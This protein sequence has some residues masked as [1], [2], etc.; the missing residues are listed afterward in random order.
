MKAKI[1][2]LRAKNNKLTTLE[3]QKQGETEAA[4]AL[5]DCV[6][7]IEG[8]I[9]K[10]LKISMPRFANVS[11]AYFS[12]LPCVITTLANLFSSS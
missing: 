7:Y 1:G 10:R 11:G 4:R 5:D 12:P 2:R 6:K 8:S 9:M 3:A